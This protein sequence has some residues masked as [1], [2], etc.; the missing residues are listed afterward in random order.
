MGPR[1]RVRQMVEQRV[2]LKER[3]DQRRPRDGERREGGQRERRAGAH[4]R[5]Q[6]EAAAPPRRARRGNQQDGTKTGRAVEDV[7]EREDARNRGSEHDRV[8]QPIRNGLRAAQQR[9]REPQKSEPQCSSRSFEDN[10]GAHTRPFTL[11]ARRFLRPAKA[12]G[13]GTH[14]GALPSIASS[15]SRRERTLLDFDGRAGFGE[16]GLDLLGFVAR[17]SGLDRLG[18]ALDERFRFGETEAGEFANGLDDLDLLRA[19]F[20]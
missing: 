13:P 4:R 2:A 20:G 12:K 9:C 17:D 10:A 18:C 5:R 6:F 11:A 16:L 15:P 1:C 19:D 14:S 8:A 3:T 7:R